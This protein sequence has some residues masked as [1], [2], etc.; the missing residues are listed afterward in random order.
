ML[1]ATKRPLVPDL[2]AT[3]AAQTYPRLELVLVLHGDG[4][5]AHI[6]GAVAGLGIAARVLRVDGRHRFGTVLNRAVSVSGG[7]LLAKID[8]DDAYSDEHIWDLAVAP[9]VSGAELVAK[10][11]EFVYWPGRTGPST[12][13]REG[14]VASQIILR[15]RGTMLISPPRPDA[16]GRRRRVPRGASGF[17]PRM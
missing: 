15:G 9:R 6:E 2:L 7:T 16:A 12:D 8:D 13:S 5:G 11:S 14:G 4:F 3:V 10:G 17:H 1:A